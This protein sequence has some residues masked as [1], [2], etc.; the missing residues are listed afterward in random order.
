MTDADAFQRAILAEPAAD[1]PRLVYAD[2]LDETGDPANAARAEYIRLQCEAAGLSDFDHRRHLLE[3]RA[4]VLFG[5]RWID[6]W[7]PI[8]RRVNLPEPYADADPR[9][10][11]AVGWPYY[12][13]EETSD[14]V[15]NNYS[16]HLPWP[17][18]EFINVRFARG[19]VDELFLGG[20][21][22]PSIADWLA[23]VPA[24]RLTLVP[25]VHEDFAPDDT[26][27]LRTI[28]KLTL[29]I[30]D[31]AIPLAIL[32]SRHL[33][34][35]EELFL[36]T[37]EESPDALEL[38]TIARTPAGNRLRRL[39]LELSTTSAAAVLAVSFPNLCDLTVNLEHDGGSHSAEV[40]NGVSH[41]AAGL[42]SQLERLSLFTRGDLPPAGFRK[43]VRRPWESLRTLELLDP[44]VPADVRAL[45]A[46]AFP[47]LAELLLVLDPAASN[48]SL[49][50]LAQWPSV[51]RLTRLCFGGGTAKADPG[52]IVKLAAGLDL[53][54]LQTFHLEPHADARLKDRLSAI[55]GDRLWMG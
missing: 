7:R 49:E 21:G 8:C 41:L 46:D 33:T 51:K 16:P 27:A 5:E 2:W 50:A 52:R 10:H 23:V 24:D 1:L 35:L 39:K 19:F 13:S 9:W 43:L 25:L 22:R 53:D 44:L 37:Q 18:R 30:T 26:P 34:A 31:A 29:K 38:R 40:T 4:S 3:Q 47:Q 15:V 11:R 14:F 45:A 28:R 42:R 12:L 54:V 6:W 32:G 17:R 55:L 20:E 48:Q 36:W